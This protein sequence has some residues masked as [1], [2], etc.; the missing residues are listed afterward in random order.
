MIFEKYLSAE[1]LMEQAVRARKDWPFIEAIEKDKQLPSYCL[2]ALGSRETNLRNIVGDGGHGYGVWQ[3]DNRS[4]IIPDG[5]IKN[6][7]MQAW[8]AGQKL[9]YDY[10]NRGQQ[11]WVK[12]FNVY[13]SGQTKTENT[14]GDDYG[15]DVWSRLVW[16][17]QNLAPSMDSVS[18]GDGNDVEVE[19]L[20]FASAVDP[21]TG[22]VWLCDP[23][24]GGVYSF[25]SEGNEYHR[26]YSAVNAHPELRAGRVDSPA[27]K[28][29]GFAYWKNGNGYMQFTRE[30]NGT[31][32]CYRWNDGTKPV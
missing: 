29:I 10:A 20:M 30:K 2:Y 27:G 14:T 23:V 19:S 25:D 31:I 12:T 5:F 8:Y 28:M 9:K 7:E 22:D 26:Y 24:D 21:N 1:K 4:H 32:H 15:P 6:V 3:L 18:G 16:L 17:Q 11:D 13:N